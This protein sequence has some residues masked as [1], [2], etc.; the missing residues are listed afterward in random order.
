LAHPTRRLTVI[1]EAIDV[2]LRRLSA[3]AP[4]HEVDE[5]RAK[6]E[7]FLRT[8]AGWTAS[9]PPAQE[10]ERLMMRVLKLHVDAAKL[11]RKPGT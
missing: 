4:S 11:E 2:V 6:A 1:K 10:K 5:L 8:T 9:H 7:E 3:L